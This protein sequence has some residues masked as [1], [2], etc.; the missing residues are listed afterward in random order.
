MKEK[1]KAFFIQGIKLI[2]FL[3][4]LLVVLILVNDVMIFKQEDGTNPVRNF[5]DLPQD[6]VDVLII[7]TSHAGMNIST[8]T[9]WNEYGI[10]GYRFWGS[11]QPIWNSYF[12][13]QE[14]LKYQNPKVVV[15]DLHSLSFVQD[16]ANYAVQVKNTV[17]LNYSPLRLEAGRLTTHH[18]PPTGTTR[19]EHPIWSGTRLG[20]GR[21]RRSACV[22]L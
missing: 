8:K 11:I 5:Y 3:A 15:I 1:V 4:G 14:A 16:Y 7:G 17:G 6:T 12:Y 18:Q 19:N 10:A 13:L 9:L 22:Y 20:A 21:R 2:C